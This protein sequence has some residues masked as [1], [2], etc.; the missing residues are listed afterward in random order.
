MKRII[1]ERAYTDLATI[2]KMYMPSGNTFYTIELPWEANKRSVSCIPEGVYTLNKRQSGVVNR[3]SKGRYSAGWEVANVNGR[4]FIMI[5]IAN[6]TSDIEGCIG[7]GLKL[8]VV[9]DQWAVLDSAAAFDKF[10]AEMNDAEDWEIVFRVRT[11]EY[12]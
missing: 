8:G 7:I 1:I 3:T 12:P 11:I 10:M 6:T 5:H 2:G 9:S 4:T